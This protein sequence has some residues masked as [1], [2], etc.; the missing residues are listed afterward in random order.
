MPHEIAII[1]GK[2]AMMFVKEPP[3]HGLGHK[4]KIA[5]KTAEQAI[6]AANLDWRVLKKPVYAFD[7][8]NFCSIPGH[9]VTVREDL[10]GKPECK[11]FG[12]VGDNYQVLQNSEAFSFFDPIIQSGVV[13]YETAGALGEGERI[14]VLAKVKEDI[15]VKGKDRL[16]RYLLLTNGHNGRIALQ[17][18]FTPVRVVCTNTLSAALMSGN[19]FTKLYHG[20][21]LH[22]RLETT[23]EA[24]KG[25]LGHYETLANHFENFAKIEMTGD[26][27]PKY[28]KA[29][30]P[31]PKRKANQKEHSYQAA[32]EK[33]NQLRKTSEQLSME[34]L[35]NK[36]SGIRGT[37]WLAYNGVTELVDH[38]LAYN[39]PSQRLESVCFGEGEQIKQRAF[40]AAVQFSK[41]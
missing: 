32:V 2:P 20:K 7:G 10:W 34:D 3:W 21:G 33:N 29:V 12:L 22:R 17:V 19:D 1:N 39:N 14:W 36:E 13:T 4:F 25:I 15:F 5:P 28:L 16:E 11:P 9:Q 35:G 23:Q 40:D 18:R 26:K 37:L 8:G 38:Y 31:D 27:L 24:M 41:N 6:R 30:F